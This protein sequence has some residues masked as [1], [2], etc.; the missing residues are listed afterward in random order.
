MCKVID[1]PESNLSGVFTNHS[2]LVR[3]LLSFAVILSLNVNV[4]WAGEGSGGAP[5]VVLTISDSRCL[6]NGEPTF[7]LGFSYFAAL[8]APEEFI[9][10][11]LD[12][13]Q[14]SGFNWL[15]VW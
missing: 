14:H 3:N 2:S 15:R 9:S 7:L 13:F 6:I 12:D 10:R 11:D 5:K 8:G 4:L 1:L